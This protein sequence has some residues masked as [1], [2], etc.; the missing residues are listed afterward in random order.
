MAVEETE[1]AERAP[2]EMVEMEGPEP[3]VPEEAE[4]EEE[5]VGLPTAS[6]ATREPP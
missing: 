5:W 4:G 6:S 3:T 2:Q 1:L